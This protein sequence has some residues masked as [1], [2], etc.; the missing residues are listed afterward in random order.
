MIREIDN[1]YLTKEEPV[2]SCLM[3]LREIILQYNE[4]ITETWKYKMPCYCY[5][6]KIFCYVWI[7]RK[8]NEPY[9]LMVEGRNINHPKLEQGDR[10]RMKRLLI[11]PKKDIPITT[12]RTIFKMA[13]KFYS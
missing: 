3:A 4:N 12:I 1:F 2:K 5:K 10:S 9:I 11:H 7:D 13:L 8:I 6:G